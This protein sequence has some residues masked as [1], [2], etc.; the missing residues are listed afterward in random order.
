MNDKNTYIKLTTDIQDSSGDSELRILRD[1][2]MRVVSDELDFVMVETL[3]GKVT[4]GVAPEDFKYIDDLDVP[5]AFRID[6]MKAQ[7]RN[8]MIT[9]YVKWAGTHG[10][11][12]VFA[13]PV[14]AVADQ[15]ARTVYLKRY[16][17]LWDLTDEEIEAALIE[18]GPPEEQTINLW[19]EGEED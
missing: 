6:A 17:K 15:T 2:V 5:A 18:H 9:Y 3:D 19:I 4:I 16:Q 8:R 12:N 10:V 11:V 13:Q 14:L 7:A 1:T